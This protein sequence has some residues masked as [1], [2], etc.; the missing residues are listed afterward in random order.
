MTTLTLAYS[1]INKKVNSLSFPN[2][3][4]KAYC[5][6]GFLIILS[7]SIFYVVYI[8]NMTHVTYLIKDYQAQIDNLLAENKTLEQGFARTSFMGTIG[9][10]TQEMSFEKVQEVKYIQIL[11]ASVAKIK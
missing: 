10:R 9:D 6:C 3:N 4:W 7:L 2:I 8:N 1:S 5:L 11:E